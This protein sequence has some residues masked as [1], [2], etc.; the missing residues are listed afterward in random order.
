M[1]IKN[2]A[3]GGRGL[4]V[5]GH[6]TI[7]FAPGEVREVD[8]S[9]IEIALQDP[10]NAA[11]LTEEG[12]LVEAPK[13]IAGNPHAKP[14]SP[15]LTN[16]SGSPEDVAKINAAAAAARADAEARAK[17]DAEAEAK[18]ADEE[19]AKAAAEVEAK[20]AADAKLAETPK[21]DE[22]AVDTKKGP[23]K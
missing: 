6:G 20:L 17:A 3:E 13:G 16:P 11:T 7:S 10:A 23:K 14:G 12:G 8:D 9:I 4:G 1:L 5:K 18:R 15:A 2:I 22:P 19:K 21:A